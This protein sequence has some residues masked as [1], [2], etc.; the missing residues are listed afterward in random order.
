MYCLRTEWRVGGDHDLLLLA[1]LDQLVL[2]QVRVTFDLI[3][4]RTNFGHV[5]NSIN[6]SRIEIGHSDRFHF[7]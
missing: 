5:Q 7:A 1:V 2:R 4:H 6:L 3:D